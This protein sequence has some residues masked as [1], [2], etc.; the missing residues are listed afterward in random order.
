MTSKIFWDYS[1]TCFSNFT[2]DKNEVPIVSIVSGD[3]KRKSRSP[4]CVAS[5]EPE[6]NDAVRVR[7]GFQI[8]EIFFPSLE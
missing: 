5:I 7:E 1:H 4:S 2:G 3:N 6:Q 8:W